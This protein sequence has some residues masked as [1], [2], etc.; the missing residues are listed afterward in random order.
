[1]TNRGSGIRPMHFRVTMHAFA[2]IPELDAGQAE[3]Q[4]VVH[5]PA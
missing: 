2:V 1:M 5:R 4:I 3:L